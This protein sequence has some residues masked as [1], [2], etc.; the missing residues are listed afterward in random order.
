MSKNNS[1]IL[2]EVETLLNYVAVECNDALNIRTELLNVYTKNII[3][4]IKR[5]L[6]IGA[7]SYGD[8]VPIT[9]SDLLKWEKKYGKKRDNLIEALEEL[10][11]CAVYLSAEFQGPYS[12]DL[13]GRK[14]SLTSH[15][16]KLELRK[17][18]VHLA[19]CM[20]YLLNAEAKR[21]NYVNEI[22]LNTRG[23]NNE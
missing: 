1:K 8:E 12:K 14:D 20:F 13:Q 16:Y 23:D 10:L 15:Y 19:K 6:K 4:F 9:E 2:K 7:K 21:T 5:R 22:K 3:K 18:R 17:A 11:D